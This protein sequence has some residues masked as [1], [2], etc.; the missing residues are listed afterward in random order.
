ML[1][2]LVKAWILLKNDLD[3]QIYEKYQIADYYLVEKKLN[4]I[5]RYNEL[6]AKF[7]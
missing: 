1:S 3:Q 6:R 5:D 7:R 4:Q 2:W